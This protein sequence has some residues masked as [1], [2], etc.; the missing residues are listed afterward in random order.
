MCELLIL[1]V[2]N[3]PFI[4]MANPDVRFYHCGEMPCIFIVFGNA[5]VLCKMFALHLEANFPIPIERI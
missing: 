3:V 4:D 5:Y 2:K 1:F